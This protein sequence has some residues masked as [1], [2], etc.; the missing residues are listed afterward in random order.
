MSNSSAR[1]EMTRNA[2]TKQQRRK[3]ATVKSRAYSGFQ[4][5]GREVM[6]SGGFRPLLGSVDEVPL[7]PTG[8][9]SP[10]S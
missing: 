10:R 7:R 2:I 8:T 9:L 3:H 1:H 6:G 5:R 4:V